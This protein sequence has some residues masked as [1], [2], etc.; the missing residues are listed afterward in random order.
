MQPSLGGMHELVSR[1]PSAMK[2]LLPTLF[3]GPL[4]RGSFDFAVVNASQFCQS[5]KTDDVQHG[6]R[7]FLE[8]GLR[9]SRCVQMSQ[10]CLSLA[11][12]WRTLV[13]TSRVLTLKDAL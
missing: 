9:S 12:E 6:C 3:R 8:V 4:E 7:G 5:Q 11:E 10:I 13:Q 2:I 1:C